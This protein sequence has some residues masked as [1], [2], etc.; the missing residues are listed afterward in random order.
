[1]TRFSRL[2]TGMLP[3]S[4]QAL[5]KRLKGLLSSADDQTNTAVSNMSF[6]DWNW[7]NLVLKLFILLQCMALNCI[8]CSLSTVPPSDQVAALL[9]SEIA[10]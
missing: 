10:G 7:E 9:V 6:A 4:I 1:M 2:P 8:G 5:Q 3:D